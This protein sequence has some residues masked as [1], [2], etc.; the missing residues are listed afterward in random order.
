MEKTYDIID[1]TRAQKPEDVAK[2]FDD[3]VNDK[4][5]TII[6][7]RKEELANKM[8]ADDDNTDDGS[9]DKLADGEKG[10]EEETPEDINV[11]DLTD[12]ELEELIASLDPETRAEL[13]KEL[14]D[15]KSSED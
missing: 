6:A 4:I 15:E 13:E 12:E 7:A 11:D 9:E 5:E 14:A 2:V 3:L 8:F 10:E 1:F